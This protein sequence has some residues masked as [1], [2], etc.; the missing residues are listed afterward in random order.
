M[1]NFAFNALIMWYQH[2]LVEQALR[3]LAILGQVPF[4]YFTQ[5][6]HV[7]LEQII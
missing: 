4:D 7:N 2:F 5:F 1:N 6:V 3:S